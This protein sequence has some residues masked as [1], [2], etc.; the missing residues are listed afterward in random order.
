[1]PL[2]KIRRETGSKVKVMSGGLSGAD[3]KFLERVHNLGGWELFDALALHPGRG[4]YTPDYLGDKGEYWTYLGTIRKVKAMVSRLGDKPIWI[5]EAYMATLPNN[6]W[7][8]SYRLAAENMVLTYA[9]A[10][11]EGI[12]NVQLYQLHDS[13]WYDI[14]G[15]DEKD[16]EYH[17]GHLFRDGG[18]KPSLLAY[19]TIAEALDR[20]KFVRWMKFSDADTKGLLFRTPDGP[21]A[22]SYT[23]LT[24]P[25]TPY[26]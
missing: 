3:V 19:C 25:T 17:H 26:V 4:H 5:T 16:M 6:W 8:D 1:M 23:H 22:V 21:V 20:A 13:V 12:R 9:L 15:V 2:S 7:F 14:G 18:I 10:M 24:L 11:A